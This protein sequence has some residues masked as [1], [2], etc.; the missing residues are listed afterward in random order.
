MERGATVENCILMQRSCVQS[1]ALLRY[2]IADK[3]VR[4]CSGRML[5]GHGTYPLVISKDEIV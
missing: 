5:M 1:D 2:T 3:N 4:V